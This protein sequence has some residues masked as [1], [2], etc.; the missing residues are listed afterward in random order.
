MIIN[1]CR[2]IFCLEQLSLCDVFFARSPV[3]SHKADVYNL[4]SE[5]RT[6]SKEEQFQKLRELVSQHKYVSTLAP[7]LED[8]IRVLI[9]L[10]LYSDERFKRHTWFSSFYI[11]CTLQALTKRPPISNCD[12]S[13]LNEYLHPDNIF[14][15]VSPNWLNNTNKNKNQ[16]SASS[17]AA[18]P[19]NPRSEFLVSDRK[20]TAKQSSSMAEPNLISSTKSTKPLANA[21]S[22]VFSAK[23]SGIKKIQPKPSIQNQNIQSKETSFE[24]SRAVSVAEFCSLTET[25][26]CN[27]NNCIITNFNLR[28]QISRL[29][30]RNVDLA[31]KKIENGFC[32]YCTYTPDKNDN[33]PVQTLKSHIYSAHLKNKQSLT[34]WHRSSCQCT[35]ASSLPE[36]DYFVLLSSRFESVMYGL[37]VD[38]IFGHDLV[39]CHFPECSEMFAVSY[40][41]LQKH[42][43]TIHLKP[44][45]ERDELSERQKTQI[46]PSVCAVQGCGFPLFHSNSVLLQHYAYDHKKVNVV[47]Q[48]FCIHNSWYHEDLVLNGFFYEPLKGYKQWACIHC[49]QSIREDQYLLHL[50]ACLCTGSLTSL[51]SQM[52]PTLEGADYEN[53][54]SLLLSCPYQNCNKNLNLIQ[55]FI[56]WLAEHQCASRKLANIIC[57]NQEFLSRIPFL[58]KP[59]FDQL[60]SVLEVKV[61]K[62]VKPAPA[63]FVCP[64]CR[65]Q[66]PPALNLISIHINR[67]IAQAGIHSRL[68]REK[69]ADEFG[70]QGRGCPFPDCYKAHDSVINSHIT[71]A[72]HDMEVCVFYLYTTHELSCLDPIKPYL[73]E[74]AS[75]LLKHFKNKSSIVVASFPSTVEDTIRPV[76]GSSEE[77][78]TSWEPSP[79]EEADDIAIIEP[80]SSAAGGGV[81]DIKIVEVSGNHQTKRQQTRSPGIGIKFVLP[82]SVGNPSKFIA[83]CDQ[84]FK[85]VILLNTKRVLAY[86][87][88]KEFIV[89]LAA[90]E[91]NNRKGIIPEVT[92]LSAQINHVLL[93]DEIYAV[94]GDLFRFPWFLKVWNNYH[95]LKRFSDHCLTT[96]HGMSTCDPMQVVIIMSQFIE[97]KTISKGEVANFLAII[98][99]VHYK[100]GSLSLVETHIIKDFVQCEDVPIVEFFQLAPNLEKYLTCT[101]CFN[102]D[103]YFSCL[104]EATKHIKQNHSRASPGS[105]GCTRCYTPKVMN[106]TNDE[107]SITN[108]QM[109]MGLH[110]NSTGQFNHTWFILLNFFKEKK[111]VENSSNQNCFN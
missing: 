87:L 51:M 103:C 60:K 8:A 42:L 39:Q 55:L 106:V 107:G 76:P 46:G 13:T 97:D 53:F 5:W 90:M 54:T 65:Q 81:C 12:A 45:V 16:V 69:L 104:A 71:S 30:A 111:V 67:H 105:V 91:V 25:T 20:V 29:Y 7:A 41:T 101:S 10:F 33:F 83:Q 18:G 73:A 56:H 66:Y 85:S 9:P 95:L 77:P 26:S 61:V 70:Y 49:R 110:T 79:S 34:I 94:P 35:S 19:K 72:S 31:H 62:L 38:D 17:I 74:K 84:N 37:I 80:N 44:Y 2:T 82:R 52:S 11:E 100:I 36:H 23:A 21:K 27:K 6:F 109:Q 102:F 89:Y 43:F 24:K 88:F 1:L 86:N 59:F 57:I 99:E 96:K 92:A 15:I 63:K 93:H 78:S 64:Q 47:Y 4:G 48:Q 75:N 40:G 32:M 58:D 98:N 28:C 3:S 108:F 50:D 22:V 68:L 14:S